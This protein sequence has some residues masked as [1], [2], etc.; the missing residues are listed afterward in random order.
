MNTADATGTAMTTAEAFA[1]CERIARTHYENFP[2]GSLLVPAGLRPHF[3]SIYAYSRAADDFADEG[4]RTVEERIAALDAWEARLEDAYR[5]EADHPVFV[6]LAETVRRHAVPIEPLRDLLRAFRLDSREEGFATMAELL[7]YCRWSADPVGRLVLH[8]FELATPERLVL[9]D[10]ICTALQ[11]ANFW[12]DISVD[13]PRGRFTVPRDV[14]RRFG[15]TAEDLRERRFTENVRAMMHYLVDDAEGRF[16]TGSALIRKVP[17][18]RLRMELAL[19]VRG[20]RTIL[21]KI[22]EADYNVLAERP[23]IGTLDKLRILLG[24][25]L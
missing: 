5:G 13:V 3:Y 24:A 2:V 15:C 14:L 17:V 20:G 19:V 23:A 25:G 12:Q 16:R 22:R 4:D 7:D 8:L 9:S 1:Y 10:A 18:F 6:A 21:R 11:L